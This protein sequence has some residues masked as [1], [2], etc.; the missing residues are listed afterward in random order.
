VE[1]LYA[2]PCVGA[3]VF[4]ACMDVYHDCEGERE[5]LRW[6][7]KCAYDNALDHIWGHE[8]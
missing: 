3:E 7:C 1:F 8:V 2:I 6:W 5:H 4:M